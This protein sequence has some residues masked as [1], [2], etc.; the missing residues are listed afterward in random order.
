MRNFIF[1]FL[2][3]LFALNNFAQEVGCFNLQVPWQASESTSYNGVAYLFPTLPS[4]QVDPE[5]GLPLYV[6]THSIPVGM[7]VE[8]VDVFPAEARPLVVTDTPTQKNY[9]TIS[10]FSSNW[11]IGVEKKIASLVVSF[12]PLFVDENGQ[13]M[14]VNKANVR[15]SF[16]KKNSKSLKSSAVSFASKSILSE[17]KWVKI[18]VDKTGIHQIDYSTLAQWGFLDPSKVK[19]FGNG[20]DMLPRANNS[21][22]E[23]DLVENGVYDNGR[24][25]LFYAK[26]CV[27]W[28]YNYDQQMY[29]HELNDYD[30]SSYYFLTQNDYG[31]KGFIPLPSEQNPTVITSNY[32]SYAYHEQNLVNLIK[33]GNE[34]LG[35]Q[36]SSSGGLQ[37]TITFNTPDI[38]TDSIGSIKLNVQLVA[39]SDKNSS[40]QIT[41]N[42][43]LTPDLKM[44]F[45]SVPIGSNTE[46]YADDRSG[47][48]TSSS[49]NELTS[50]NIEYIAPSSVSLGWINSVTL[51]SYNNLVFHGGELQFRNPHVVGEGVVSQFNMTGVSGK[52]IIV[53]DVT[54]PVSP[55]QVGTVSNLDVLSFS[56]KTET[57]QEFVAFE[58]NSSFPSPTFVS[59]IEN[60][61]LHGLPQTDYV[62]VS[63]VEFLNQAKNLAKIHEDYNDIIPT[64][65]TTDQI[66]NEFSSGKQDAMAIRAFMRM[67]YAR[68]GADSVLM[69]KYLLLYGDASYDNLGV[70]PKN[71]CKIVSFESDKSFHQ[72]ESYVTDDVFGFLDDNEGSS[73]ISDKLDIGIGRFVIN[74]TDEANTANAKVLAYLTKQD[75][76]DWQTRVTFLAQDADDNLHQ[77]DAEDLSVQIRNSNPEFEINKIFADSY[78]KFTNSVYGS[79]PDADVAIQNALVNNG[80][81]IFNY[82]GHGATTM[83][84]YNFLNID[85]VDKLNNI[86]RLPLFITASCEIS[87]FDNP[88]EKS[89]GEHI[90]LNPIG[91]GIGLLSTTRVV[92]SYFNKNINT[93]FYKN[94]FLKDGAN[95]RLR[96]G[97]IMRRTKNGS[98]PS[99]N[100]LNFSLLCDP[101]L[102][103][104]YP[105]NRTEV[106]EFRNVRLNI[107]TDTIHGLT[108]GS[109]TGEVR[110]KD[111]LPLETYNGSATITLYDKMSKVKTLGNGGQTPFEYELYQNVLY[112]GKADVK[113]GMFT[114]TFMIPQ[115]IRYEFGK[116]KIALYT[117]SN[118]SISSFGVNDDIV[119]GG[120]DPNAEFNQ[121]GPRIRMFLNDTIS[122][123]DG[124]KTG[125]SPM[126]IAKISDSN[127]INTAGSG[128]GHDLLL[129]IDNNPLQSYNMNSFFE[130]EPNRY[131]RG[132]IIFQLGSL[133]PG[134]HTATLR[135]WDCNNNSTVETISFQV[136]AD[137]KLGIMNISLYPNPVSNEG[138]LKIFFNHDEPNSTLTISMEIYSVDGAIIDRK[139]FI[140]IDHNGVTPLVEWSPRSKSG[141]SLSAGVYICKL[142]ITS[143]NGQSTNFSKRFVILR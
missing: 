124:C 93:S 95:E 137:D 34:W 69:P 117:N 42:D 59:N 96:L 32:I 62:I 126:L 35:E 9:S 43:E 28:K 82:T 87:R 48:L 138:V 92:Y 101:G 7:E 72:T 8:A 14:A 31:R 64:V 76:T 100:K 139:N 24:A 45:Y 85:K 65:V 25:L 131:D 86:L 114:A 127:G 29:I 37:R 23:D 18:K 52:E 33:S 16:A 63:P 90:F 109:I 39:R 134:I 21:P 94:A 19:V 2:L 143:S 141:A 40:F 44:Y 36:F 75:Q 104:N 41:L 78:A 27:N 107:P 106:A 123:R 84:N 98:I 133:S 53:L 57:L 121:E 132:K 15:V 1:G 10:H 119:V 97:E 128:I 12:D 142:W 125:V 30:N 70:N 105:A 130:F 4:G 11:S 140:E 83:L 77:R 56:L 136:V 71:K 5:S 73:D 111:D 49:Y 116:G 115:D 89:M 61:N 81:L 60:Q 91:G 6:F 102:K 103:L 99:V 129:T 22:R 3:S 47:F 110:S 54:K 26:G 112:R 122:F 68:A 79:F 46:K 20:G 55:I 67:F 74:S 113:D 108:L 80:T 51:N 38:C 17:G 118:D 66:F 58:P 13:L 135:V 120:L 50:V 88:E